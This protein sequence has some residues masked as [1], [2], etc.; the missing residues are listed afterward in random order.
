M[1]ARQQSG[2]CHGRKG[3]RHCDRAE[4]AQ[5]LGVPSR[6]QNVFRYIVSGARWERH[7]KTSQSPVVL[8]IQNAVKIVVNSM[9]GREMKTCQC[10]CY[11]ELFSVYLV[12]KYTDYLIKKFGHRVSDHS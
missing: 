11:T 1:R 4:H 9:N 2:H 12:G 8:R 10:T 3:E 6:F 5:N 7:R